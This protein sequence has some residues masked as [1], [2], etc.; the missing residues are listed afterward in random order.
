MLESDC[1]KM[2]SVSM[3]IYISFQVFCFDFPF[4]FS[5]VLLLLCFTI[6]LQLLRDEKVISIYLQCTHQIWK[7]NGHKKG[8]NKVYWHFALIVKIKIVTFLITISLKFLLP[9]SK[10]FGNGKVFYGFFSILAAKWG[11]T[12]F[13]VSNYI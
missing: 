4:F 10:L 13:S 7:K 3:N 12:S 9:Q 5:S 8:V 1:S 6:L 2:N 11:S